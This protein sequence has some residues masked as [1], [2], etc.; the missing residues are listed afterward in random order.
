MIGGLYKNEVRPIRLWYIRILRTKLL[1]LDELPFSRI[2]LG[3]Y[4][5]RM[6]SYQ[7]TPTETLSVVWN[8]PPLFH[9]KLVTALQ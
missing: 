6:G 8:P 5:R 4:S 1:V 3:C 7:S 9:V 2:G